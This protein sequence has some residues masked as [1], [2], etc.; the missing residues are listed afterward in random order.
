MCGRLYRRPRARARGS[1][2][3]DRVAVCLVSDEVRMGWR[4][5]QS[6]EGLGRTNVDDGGAGTGGHTWDGP[7]R[8]G[9]PAGC[10]YGL[11]RVLIQTFR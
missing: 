3:D 4:Q 5:E 10:G 2:A 9:R 11:G 8:A 7:A 1:S 6:A